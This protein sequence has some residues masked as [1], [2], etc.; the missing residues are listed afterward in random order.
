MGRP[1]RALPLL[2]AQVAADPGDDRAQRLLAE[3]AD[4]TRPQTTLDWRDFEQSDGLRI[5]QTQL[6]TRLPIEDGRG[7]LGL[8]LE[9]SV[10]RP[11]G[12]PVRHIEVLRPGVEAR[13]RYSD[14]LEWTASLHRDRID[15]HGAPGDHQ[16]WTHSTFLTLRPVDGLRLDLSS[17]RWTFDSELALR[18]GLTAWQRQVSVDLTPDDRHRLSLRANRSEY[19]DGNA[20]RGGRFDAEQRLWQ[21]AQLW[22]GY[23]HTRFGYARPGQ[24][25]YHNPERYRADELL[26]RAGGT[27][28]PGLDWGLR[29]ALGREVEQP[30]DARP[31][32]AGGVH[33]SWAVQPRLMLEAAYDHS[34]SRTLA[35]GGFERGIVRLTLR[36]R[37]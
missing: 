32:H 1:D 21:P 25:G 11:A 30:G 14:A 27:L 28:A 10:Y 3:L 13:Y 37:H 20:R 23:R 26:L 8:L 35:S 9:R 18:A 2:R 29:A 15:T 24:P 36:Y 4:A 12:G 6:A 16:R 31:I 19:S 5:G 34:S 33:L 7:H 17:Q 22:L